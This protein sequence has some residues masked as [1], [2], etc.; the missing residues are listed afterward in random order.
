[1]E[2]A[3]KRL[4]TA[5]RTPEIQKSAW[6]RHGFRCGLVGALND[7]QALRV[8]GVPA[9]I[10]NVMPMPNARVMERT[11]QALSGTQPP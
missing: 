7:P 3:G 1:M 2:R 9:A 11:I 10:E 5:L 4:L 6:E 8:P